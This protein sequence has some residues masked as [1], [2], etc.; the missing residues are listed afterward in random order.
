MSAPVIRHAEPA[1]PARP[2]ARGSLSLLIRPRPG[3]TPSNL[4]DLP[5][6][7]GGGSP[8][9][10]PPARSA[11]TVAVS[12]VCPEQPRMTRSVQCNGKFK[13]KEPRRRPRA[14]PTR[15]GDEP[16]LVGPPELLLSATALRPG[17]AVASAACT[18]SSGVRP[19][20]PPAWC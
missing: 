7:G 2:L 3:A 8:A 14:P 1:P 9:P 10:P 4:T 11:V 19:P 12:Q 15:E 5:W 20:R 13:A 17:C 16:R 6:P 18:A